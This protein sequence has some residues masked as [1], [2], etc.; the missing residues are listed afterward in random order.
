MKSIA[1]FLI[2]VNVFLVLSVQSVEARTV[3][4]VTHEIK[5][6]YAPATPTQ[7]PIKKPTTTPTIK[8]QVT[9]QN[10]PVEA[11]EIE[12]GIYATFKEE[13]NVMLAIFKHESGL[14]QYAEGFNC[15]YNREDGSRYSAACKIEDRPNAWSVDCG[16]A[17]I[18]LPNHKRC[19]DYALT[20]KWGL[21]QARGKYDRQGKNAWVSFWTGRYKSY[22]SN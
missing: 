13:P 20:V 9:P 22:L 2:S 16:F 15:Y 21:E 3:I 12:K 8:T 17:Q 1:Y 19:P 6:K 7:S 5:S 10:S 11:G 18:N 4:T 14:N